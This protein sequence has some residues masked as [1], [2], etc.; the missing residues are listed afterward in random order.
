[1]RSLVYGQAKLAAAACAGLALACSAP[2][3]VQYERRL[4]ETDAGVHHALH[5][6]RLQELMRGMDRLSGDHLPKSMDVEGERRLRAEEVSQI[7]LAL[8]ASA[9]GIPEASTAAPLS[10]ADRAE[11][12]A[13]ALQ[14]EERATALARAA[15]DLQAGEPEAQL[16]AQLEAISQTC[17]DCH[18]RFRPLGSP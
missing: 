11:F 7:A 4:E 3:Q 5:D 6:E 2:L 10:R 1:V 14:L 13:L 8:S 9:A 17:E 18:T 16:D 12:E 15:G